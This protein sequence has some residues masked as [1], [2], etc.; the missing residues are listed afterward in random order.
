MNR[1][2]SYTILLGVLVF[3]LCGCKEDTVSVQMQSFRQAG[4][5]PVKRVAVVDFAGEGGQAVA[6]ILSMH[7]ARCGY[8][9][10]ERQNID[11]LLGKAINPIEKG[12]TTATVTERLN[13]MGKLLN[14]DAIITG[15]LVTM[16]GP[17]Y[18][19]DSKRKNLI[20][21]G[22]I[23]Q[24]SARAF[25]VRTREIFWT[26]VINV[27]ASARTGE[28]LGLLG[29]VDQACYELVESFRSENYTKNGTFTYKGKAIDTRKH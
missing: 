16:R 12:E 27:V 7:L 18:M 21:E 17:F 29:Y 8:K 15:D 22:A 3:S 28:N 14:A 19:P 23:C 1:F 5:R 9:V 24:I 10:V 6:D 26:G 13:T 11:D 20:Y 4:G 2:I 25:D